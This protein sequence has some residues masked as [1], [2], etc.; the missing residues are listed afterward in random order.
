MTMAMTHNACIASLLERMAARAAHTRSSAE[1]WRE[2]ALFMREV[3]EDLADLLTGASIDDVARATHFSE[4]I[5]AAIV[6]AASTGSLAALDAFDARER[7][8]RYDNDVGDDDA[9][10]GACDR[11]EEGERI[12]AHEA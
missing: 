1:E 7:T 2:A 8:P 5:A 6:E 10:D 12:F 9:Q 11:D 4:E 3:D